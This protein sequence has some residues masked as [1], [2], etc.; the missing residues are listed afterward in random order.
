[1]TLPGRQRAA[2]IAEVQDPLREHYRDE[3]ADALITDRGRSVS[4]RMDDPVHTWASPG[5]QDYGEPWPLG[6][7]RAVGG[8]HD[9]PNPGDLLCQALASC[10]DS[11]VRMIADRHGIP[12]QRLEVEVEGDVDVRGTLRVS[13]EVP[14]GFQQLRCRVRAAL[15]PGV[16]A[17]LVR[18]LMAASEHSCVNLATLRGGVPIDVDCEILEDAGTS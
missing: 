1:M 16:D 9:A 12:L 6:V 10:M 4:I 15:L 2:G 14:V 7:H 3:P 8:L 11:V 18:K 17:A 5:S 13:R